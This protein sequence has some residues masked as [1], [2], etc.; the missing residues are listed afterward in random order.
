MKEKNTPKKIWK[1]AFICCGTSCFF[2]HTISRTKPRQDIIFGISTEEVR[3]PRTAT[4][5]DAEQGSGKIKKPR[6]NNES[7]PRL[8]RS[9]KSF[10][11]RRMLLN[12]RYMRSRVR[13]LSYA[14]NQPETS[15]GIFQ[16]LNFRYTKSLDVSTSRAGSI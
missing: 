14:S 13:E 8:G 12:R 6:R 4:T 2:L 3:L 15:R 9:V 11:S 16:T 7:S 1:P 10:P 5:N